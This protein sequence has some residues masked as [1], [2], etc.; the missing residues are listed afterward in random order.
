MALSGY[1]ARAC[2]GLGKRS[3]RV[4]GERTCPGTTVDG[5]MK[6]SGGLWHNRAFT[7][8]WIAHVTSGA[9][10]AI[11]TVALPLTAVLVLGATP[12][13]MGLLA[14]AS[15]LPNLLFGFIAGVWVDRVRR[16]PILVWAD[17]GRALLL[18]SIPAAAWMGQLTFFT[19][20][21]WLPSRPVH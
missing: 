8:L 12:S 15:S 17:I 7:R 2:G 10:T 13:E 18:V 1:D 14:A 9:G 21:D 16:R 4:D 6:Q 11:T 3:Q 19:N 5:L 20:L